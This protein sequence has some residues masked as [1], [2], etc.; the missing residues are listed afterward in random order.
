MRF[1]KGDD[2]C[3]IQTRVTFK[4]GSYFD[5]TVDYCGKETLIVIEE[6]MET[7]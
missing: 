6:E 5:G 3:E 1:Y 7:M 4:D 2:R